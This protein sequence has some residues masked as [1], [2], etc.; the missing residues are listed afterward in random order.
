VTSLSGC[1]RTGDV[2]GAPTVPVGR[3]AIPH[4]EGHPGTQSEPFPPD[5]TANEESDQCAAEMNSECCVSIYCDVPVVGNAV[6]CRFYAEDCF[7][8]SFTLELTPAALGKGWGGPASM[9]VLTKGAPKPPGAPDAIECEPC[10]WCLP[11]VSPCDLVDCILDAAAGYPLGKVQPGDMPKEGENIIQLIL[12]EPTAY[13]PGGPN[14]NTFVGQVAKACGM[15]IPKDIVSGKPLRIAPG[16][17][18]D[19][20]RFLE[21]REEWLSER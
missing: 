5:A 4:H 8:D 15:T 11:D 7:G 2:E 19:I 18:M 13:K 21:E 14:S 16:L 20:T 1:G 12:H 17:N 3:F 9:L 6:H 10:T